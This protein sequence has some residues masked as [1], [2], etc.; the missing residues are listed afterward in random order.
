[1]PISRKSSKAKCAAV[2]KTQRPAKRKLVKGKKQGPSLLILEC[3]ARKLEQ[4]SLSIARELDASVRLLVPR[5]TTAMVRT[6]S[7][8]DLLSQLA[9]C[10]EGCGEFDLVVVI[11]H[12]NQTGLRLTS[13]KGES[14]ESFTQWIKPFKP[15]R[16]VLLACKA[17]QL[18]PAGALFDGV[19]TLKEIYAS[20]TYVT[21]EQSKLLALM[22]IYLLSVKTQDPDVL[23][24]LQML[25]FV[26]S[27]GIIFRWTRKEYLAVGLAEAV[28]WDLVQHLIDEY[29]QG[30][31]RR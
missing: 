12:S 19:S 10:K 9:H 15:K 2:R 20:P 28:Q 30:Q 29:T 14:W 26:L 11:G 6:T 3:D 25:N 4:Q 31:L 27:L 5:V 8:A 1:M 24:L 22:I 13:E 7:Q 18:L 21:K 16:I 23:R 17:G